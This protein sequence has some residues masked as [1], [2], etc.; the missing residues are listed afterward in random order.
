MRNRSSR[1]AAKDEKEN[2]KNSPTKLVRVRSA[3]ATHD[4][5]VERIS[6]DNVEKRNV[7]NKIAK[8]QTELS[9]NKGM[10]RE[11]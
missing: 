11:L 6:K 1:T 5:S 4:S 3:K 2:R 9:P 10:D 8:K 7:K